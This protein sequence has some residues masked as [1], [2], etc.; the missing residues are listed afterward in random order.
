MV[1]SVEDIKRDVRIALDQNNSSDA[2]IETGDID[3]L[4]LEEIIESKIEDAAKVV[5]LD[6]PNYMLESGELFGKSIGWQGNVGYGAGY[7]FLPEDFLRL[8]SFQMSDWSYAVTEPIT[9]NHPLYKVQFSRFSGVR[10]N[11]Q[12]PVVAIV[13]QIGG[14]VL[15]FF[16]CAIGESVYVKQ[17]SYIPIPKIKDGEI[18]ICERLRPSVIYHTAYLVALSINDANTASAMLNISKE[19]L[20]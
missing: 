2:L 14:Q 16:S 18:D 9:A 10:G 11:P 5:T 12:N 17:A 1:Y 20:R 19:L 3:T 6:A 7:I 4:T 13:T 8:V 15:Q